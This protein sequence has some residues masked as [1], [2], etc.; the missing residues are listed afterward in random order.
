LLLGM[1]V[2]SQARGLA[3]DYGRG[4]VHVLVHERRRR[5]VQD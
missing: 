1:D 3:I 5:R 2:L 4:A